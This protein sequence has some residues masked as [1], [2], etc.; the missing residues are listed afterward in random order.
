MMMKKLLAAVLTAAALA[1]PAAAPAQTVWDSPMLLP[2]RD[3]DGI[4]IYLTDMHRGGVGVLGTWRSPVWNYGLRLGVSDGANDEN[5]AV[6][7]GIDYSGVVNTATEDFPIDV[8]WVLGVGAAL[9]DDVV[10]SAPL[11]LT[12]GYAFQ[13]EGARFTPFFTPRVVLD[14][15]FGSDNDL[16][17]DAAADLGLDLTFTGATG[18]LAGSTIRFAAAVGN[19]S[20]IGIGL[21]F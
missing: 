6:F 8:D 4:G 12:L 2:P 15:W 13:A 16:D 14:A 1:L 10:V 20:A 11:G 3:A 7:G 9:S 17:L 18:L 19:R 5:V 21:V